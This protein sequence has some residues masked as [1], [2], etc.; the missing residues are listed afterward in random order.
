[1]IKLLKKYRGNAKG[2]L[3]EPQPSELGWLKDFGYIDETVVDTKVKST[4]K[5]RS[6]KQSSKPKRS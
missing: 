5:K 3:I 4:P 6:T 2:T 1:M